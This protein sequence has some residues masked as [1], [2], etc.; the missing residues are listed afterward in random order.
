MSR[1]IDEDVLAEI[2]YN[3]WNNKEITDTKYNTFLALLDEVP[4]IEAEP[5]R[6][7]W[8]IIDP[9]IGLECSN[10]GFD[11]G[12]LEIEYANYCPSCGSRQDKE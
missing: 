5:V 9:G 4:T 10:C 6:H 2:I 11:I 8:W 1:L 3:K 12:D 7:G